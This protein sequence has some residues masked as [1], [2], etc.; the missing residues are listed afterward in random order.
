MKN[1]IYFDHFRKIIILM[2][3]DWKETMTDI[4]KFLEEDLNENSFDKVVINKWYFD[5]M[6]AE[7]HDLVKDLNNLIIISKNN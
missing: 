6:K 3:N 4:S 2:D 7:L 5:E 1:S